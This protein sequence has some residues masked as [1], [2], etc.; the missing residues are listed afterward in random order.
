[1]ADGVEHLACIDQRH[2]ACFPIAGFGFDGGLFQRR[3]DV[4]F[5]DPVLDQSDHEQTE[6]SEC[7]LHVDF[8]KQNRLVLVIDETLHFC[9]VGL[10]R[11]SNETPLRDVVIGSAVFVDSCYSGDSKG[12]IFMLGTSAVTNEADFD[13]GLSRSFPEL[14]C[15]LF[16]P[17]VFVDH[18]ELCH[19][20]VTIGV[21]RT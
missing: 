7:F 19:R 15:D 3:R 17:S 11:S 4:L 10:D 18:L 16:P 2:F 14:R 8:L 5:D 9:A 20:H 21:T 12:R 13:I 1:M 6:P